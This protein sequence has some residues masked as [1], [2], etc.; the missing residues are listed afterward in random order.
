MTDRFERWFLLAWLLVTLWIVACALL[1]QGEYGDGYQ[2]IVNARYLFGDSANYYVQR[3]P[4]AAMLLLP[5][6]VIAGWFAVDPVDVRP[7]HLYSGLWHSAYLLGCWLLL[8][9]APGDTIARLLAFGSAILTVV[10]YAYAPYLSHD[11]FPGLVY[12]G[13]IFLA[14]RWLSTGTHRDAALLVLMGA[15]ATLFKQTYAVFWISI[16]V[17]ALL[18]L[19]F[20]WNAGRVSLRKFIALS[21]LAAISAGLSWIGYA[22]FIGGELPEAAFFTRPLTL[23]TAVSAQYGAAMAG[24]F[25]ADLYLRNLPNFG[26]AAMLLALPGAWFALRGSDARMQQVAVCW[27]LAVVVMQLLEFREVRYLAFLAPLTAMLI[28]PVIQRLMV[29]RVA[30]GLLVVLV[31]A[32]QA[33]GLAV[34][35]Q[36]IASTARIDVARF[37][38]APESAA[39]MHVSQTLSFVYAGSSPLLRDRYHGIYHL[40]PHNISGLYEARVDVNTID[41]PRDLGRV[42]LRPGDRVY[43]S[44]NTIVR[45]PPWPA[46]NI[47]A[48]LGTFLLVA[49]NVAE[50]DLV[51]QNGSYARVN[52]DNSY[53]MFVPAHEV[54]PAMPLITQGILPAEAAAG[55][56]AT[57]PGAEQISVL[58][59]SI[60][61][62]CQADVCSYR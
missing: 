24:A 47:P 7:Q 8:R 16:V 40:T 59:V 31:V 62:L 60:A 14:H 12:L 36:Q 43:Y 15:A 25:P 39:R 33:R 6:E 18:S 22:W 58:G 48:S 44:N 23:M 53:V 45:V 19:V 1:V 11:I 20:R 46:D 30:A 32:D 61:A 3:G 28:V 17:Y 5:V 34:A 4:V 35:A 56:F 57:P 27:L 52:N 54:G 10:F 51:L 42:G 49:G 13:M 41:D 21:L 55:L 26:I 38:N 29:H 9:R 50:F 2:T 37:I